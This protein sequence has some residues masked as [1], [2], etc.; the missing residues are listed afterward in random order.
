MSFQP[1]EIE[2]RSNAIESQSKAKQNA[3]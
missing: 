2:L 3:N 1:L